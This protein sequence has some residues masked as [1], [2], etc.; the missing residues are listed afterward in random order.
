ML[1]YRFAPW[2]IHY[3]LRNVD[4]HIAEIKNKIKYEYQIREK[5]RNDKYFVKLI[6]KCIFNQPT[7]SNNN[8]EEYDINN[9][10]FL[11]NN[12]DDRLRNSID[13]ITDK[14]QAQRKWIFKLNEH[15][16]F[17]QLKF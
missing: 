11:N 4:G 17:S 13:H 1:L 3:K 15:Y 2:H 5:Q 9:Y 8:E 10:K 6:K 16:Y 12:N 14:E 7:K